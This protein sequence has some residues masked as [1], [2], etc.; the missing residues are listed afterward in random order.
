MLPL[1]CAAITNAVARQPLADEAADARIL[2]L[3]FAHAE[4]R[5]A[6]PRCEI[7]SAATTA[8]TTAA[9]A[10]GARG[11]MRRAALNSTSAV[12]TV[13]SGRAG[14][15]NRVYDP[16]VGLEVHVGKVGEDD[17]GGEACRGSSRR[18]ARRD[19]E[20]RNDSGASS[21]SQMSG[22]CVSVIQRG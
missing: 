8:Q 17:R 14:S 7:D 3:A 19:R 18:L 10:T 1:C 2:L 6:T 15:R 22:V 21:H 20:R 11:A 13:I 5:R 9:A 4:H 12:S 16:F